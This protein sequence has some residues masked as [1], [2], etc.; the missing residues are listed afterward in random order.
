M[1]PATGDD[2]AA[3]T[4]IVELGFPAVGPI[5]RDMVRWMRVAD[6]P[7]ADA[8]AAFFGRLGEPAVSVIAEG[9]S[10]ENCWLR[11][12]VFCQVLSAWPSE[13]IGQLTNV[14][15]MIATQPDAY[16][17]DIRSI[18]VLTKH[19]LADP[20]WLG[21]WVEFKKERL[22]VRNEL[23]TQVEEQLK[24]RPSRGGASMTE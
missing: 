23:L 2:L 3:A 5:M 13:L 17:N 16:D 15:T 14:V 21:G 9:L 11:H 20:E 7:V 4:R 22:A 6:S 8:F 12:R 19:G 1:M 18:S 10:Q 24:N